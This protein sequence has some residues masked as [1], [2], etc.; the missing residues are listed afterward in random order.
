[1]KLLSAF[2]GSLLLLCFAVSMISL[3]WLKNRSE[4]RV[5]AFL[6]ANRDVSLFRGALSIAVTWIWAPALFLCSMQAYTKGL[7]GVFWFTAPNIACF[8]LFAPLALKL[9][10]SLPRGY[11]LPEFI[12]ARFPGQRGPHIAFVILAMG[13]QLGA[14]VINSLAGGALLHAVSGLNISVSII[15]MSLIALSYTIFSGLKASVFTDVIQM[16]MVLLIGFI[17]VP[18]CVFFGGGLPALDLGLGGIEGNHRSLFDGWIA[19]S[20]GIPMTLSLLAGPLT[21]QVFY[22]RAWAVKEKHVVSTFVLGGLLFGA[23]PILLSLLGFL[24][25]PLANQGMIRVDDPQL[26]GPLV[27]ASLLPKYALYSFCVMVFAALCSTMDSSCCALGSLGSIDLYKRYLRPQ[28]SDAQLIRA[29][30]YAMIV[31]TLCGTSIALLQPKLMW[32]F[33][34]YGALASAGMFPTL[35]AVYSKRISGRAIFWAVT[36]SMLVGTPISLYANLTEN[37]YWIVLSAILSVAI[38]LLVSTFSLLPMKAW[39]REANSLLNELGAPEK[40][41]A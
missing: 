35:F 29:S 6:V 22:Q 7:P 11:T 34:I 10:R 18:A 24:G 23:V 5:E 17:L 13:Y 36:L 19:F 33:L 3:V 8:F 21:D 26:V 40:V 39:R 38:G 15:G 14:I 32:A 20:M 12:E 2:E 28:A 41:T 27:I 4:H 25:V 37:P 31:G 16:G 9:R 30:R 1:M